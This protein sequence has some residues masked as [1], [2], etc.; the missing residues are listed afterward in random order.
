MLVF[1]KSPV[2]NIR[3]MAL[4]LAGLSFL[5]LINGPL[6]SQAE[7]DTGKEVM[8]SKT[9]LL[10]IHHSCGGMLLA[11]PGVQ[12]GGEKGTG[13]RCI[14]TAHPNGGGLRTLLEGQG[15]QV[16]ELSYESR[17]GED[18]DIQHWRAKFTDQMG[19][20]LRTANQDEFLPENESN[21]I[22]VFKSCYP[23]NDYVGE[24]EEPGDPDSPVRTVANSK[25]TYNSLLPLFKQHPEVLF[26]AFTAPP[27]AEP[28]ASGW[29]AKIKSLFG[30]KP[31]DA[32]YARQFNSWMA[33]TENGWLADYGQSNVAVFDFYDI[34]TEN[35]QSNWSRFPTRDGTDSHPSVDG[36][37][38]AAAAFV[39]FLKDKTR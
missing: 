39:S 14:Y 26:I 34:L 12:V 1:K 36:N 11:D 4:F 21:R 28:I 9:N 2:K 23:N 38:K 16:N 29:K 17:L 35:G 31:K 7:T 3:W 13:S 8:E 18:T 27:R 22:V 32:D 20:L 10:F 33:D 15:Y 19:D 37:Q 5:C 30:K 6:V 24:G 25:A